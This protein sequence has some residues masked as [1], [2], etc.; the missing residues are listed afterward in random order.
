MCAQGSAP[1]RNRVDIKL[2]SALGAPGWVELKLG[3]ENAPRLLVKYAEQEGRAVVK[4]MII[5]GGAIDSATL[6]A[7]PIGRVE[8]VLNPPKLGP[9]PGVFKAVDAEVLSELA[10]RG[11]L[12]PEEL[13]AIDAALDSFERKSPLSQQSPAS[14]GNQREPLSR[15]DGSDPDGFS[16]RVAEAYGEAVATTAHPAKRLAEEAGVPVTTVHRWIRE[17]RQRGFLPPARKGR[18]G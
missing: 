5:L 9:P 2:I 11:I 16:R 1:Y 15:P 18:A 7:I 13:A 10:E 14:R 6:R 4:R 8:S 12:F 17:A 3:G